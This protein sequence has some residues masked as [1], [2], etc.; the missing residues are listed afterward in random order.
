M[1]ATLQLALI[2]LTA[3][4]CAHLDTEVR[5]PLLSCLS[6]THASHRQHG[7]M[8]RAV[9]SRHRDHPHH[10]PRLPSALPSRRCLLGPCTAVPATAFRHHSLH[11]LLPWRVCDP[12]DRASRWT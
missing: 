12:G 6:A 8:A 1:W 10:V 7:G 2:A 11:Q 4:D 9:R 5:L 3:P